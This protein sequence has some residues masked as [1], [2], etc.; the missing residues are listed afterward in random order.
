MKI[1]N[2]LIYG[3]L[4]VIAFVISLPVILFFPSQISVIGGLTFLLLA[5]L[6]SIYRIDCSKQAQQSLDNESSNQSLNELRELL[7]SLK[8]TINN[9]TLELKDELEQIQS[10]LDCA[11]KGLVSSF[12]GL[13]QESDMQK[14]MVFDLVNSVSN[15]SESHTGIQDLAKDAATTLQGFVANE[16]SSLDQPE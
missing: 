13:Q 4:P 5:S 16:L 2:L 8:N 7:T 12:N 3:S 10:L 6:F 15:D 9:E 14:N 11:I 1:K